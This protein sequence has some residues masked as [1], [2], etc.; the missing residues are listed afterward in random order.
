MVGKTDG[1]LE[2][3]K[4]NGGWIFGKKRITVFLLVSFFMMLVV[5][6]APHRVN[7][8]ET[9]AAGAAIA[10]EDAAPGAVEKTAE[11]KAG[12]KKKSWIWIA[13]AAGVI[14]A[15]VLVYFFVINRKYTLTVT[16]G[17]GVT[18]TPA[19]GVHKYKKKEV[20]AYQY[21]LQS[22]YYNLQVKVDDNLVPAS[23]TI[24][25]GGNRTLSAAAVQGA[26][27]EVNSTPAGIDIY[28]N[29]TGTGKT[30]PHTFTL[31]SAG[32]VTVLLRKCGYKDY[33][34]TVLTEIGKTASVNANV[35]SGHREDFD[36][37]LSACWKPYSPEFWSLGGGF[38]R[39]L[40][41]TGYPYCDFNTLTGQI[42]GNSFTV[43]VGVQYVAGFTNT[44]RGIALN[45]SGN[46]AGNNGFE[47]DFT[48]A[49]R[50]GIFK[51]KNYDYPSGYG[52]W[53][54]VAAGDCSAILPG[55]SWNVLRIVRN[56][57]D[58]TFYINDQLAASFS[59]GE[60]DPRYV[61]IIY[62]NL[63]ST[64]EMRYD[65]VYIDAGNTAGAIPGRPVPVSPWRHSADKPAIF[66]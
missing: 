5:E 13:A 66:R 61:A 9:P 15:A 39:F 23:G 11:V 22:G 2:E 36:R 58:F 63:S 30:T 19:A 25:M 4:M 26:T 20:V 35:A 54:S 1:S 62:Y 50:Y 33:Q 31:E 41:P 37:P 21:S 46:S 7:A 27:L 57:N 49:G 18:G 24:T 53:Q 59:D 43:T 12:G 45:T 47:F 52:N 65:Y 14:T 29:G 16:Q 42:A 55:Q 44:P 38:Y 51:N 64:N 32:S 40:K 28:L 56:G 34:T 17:Q 48:P 60:F 6:A 3:A 10:S 8:P